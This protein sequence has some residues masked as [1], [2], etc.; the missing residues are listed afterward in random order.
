MPDQGGQDLQSVGTHNQFP[1]I[2]PAVAGDSP[3]MGKLVEALVVEPD[4][5][6]LDRPIRQPAHEGDDQARIDPA[7]EQGSQRNVGDHVAAGR[8]RSSVSRSA[9]A[10][11]SSFRFSLGE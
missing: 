8:P 9:S 10:A 4:A 3:G 11:S 6:R 2:G 1:V 7:G 5:E